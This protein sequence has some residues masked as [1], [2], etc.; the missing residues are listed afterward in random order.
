MKTFNNSGSSI[1]LVSSNGPYV[2]LVHGLGLNKEMW[3]WQTNEL[4]KNFSVVTYDLIGHGESKDPE[5]KLNLEKF[6][7]QILEIMNFLS[8]KKTSLI[9]FSLG[10][11][12]VRKFA[13]KY[14]EKLWAL[15]VLNSAH[16][17][18]QKAKDA[19]QLRVNKVKIDGPQATTED[20]L[21]RWFTKE[22]RQNN[23]DLMNKIRNWVMENKKDVYPK[24]YQV[25]V[26]GVDELLDPTLPINCPTLILTGDE[27]F[28]NSPQMSSEI[29]K[30]IK[31][32]ELKILPG[33]R[34]MA[35][36][37]DASTVNNLL[38]EFLLRN[39]N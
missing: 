32:S 15:A 3:G 39:V 29:S 22:Y 30:Q 11:M 19:V 34:H 4:S 38:L 23:P 7:E 1:N 16:K 28:G 17:R 20:A 31:G 35:L 21:N 2:I 14:S 10:G 18:D 37:E 24:A 36:I 26:D 5:G 6:S 12:I 13:I 9:G 25:L 8:I 27:D 33:L